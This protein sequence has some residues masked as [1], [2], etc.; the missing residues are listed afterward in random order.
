MV[1]VQVLGG[2]DGGVGP[3]AGHRGLHLGHEDPLPTD[4][5]ERGRQVVAL[6]PDHDRLDLEAGCA[7]PAATGRS[8]SV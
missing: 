1:E 2:V 8:S 4:L 3:S 6:R 7:G 5:I